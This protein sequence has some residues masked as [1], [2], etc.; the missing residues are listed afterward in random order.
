MQFTEKKKINQNSYRVCDNKRKKKSMENELESKKH[1]RRITYG[2]DIKIFV[3][4]V[5]S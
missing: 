3:Q 4:Q 2:N 5:F 1:H